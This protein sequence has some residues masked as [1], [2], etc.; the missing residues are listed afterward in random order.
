MLYLF[1]FDKNFVKSQKFTSI[2]DKDVCVSYC[3]YDDI[4]TGGKDD[5]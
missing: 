3:M 5:T 1:S 4:F 2:A